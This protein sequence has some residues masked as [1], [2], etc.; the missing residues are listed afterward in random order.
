MA[1]EDGDEICGIRPVQKELC[2]H[3]I[4]RYRGDPEEAS[5]GGGWDYNECV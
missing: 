3:C 2:E 4:W 1:K 5:G